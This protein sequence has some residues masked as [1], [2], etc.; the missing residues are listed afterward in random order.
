M[1]GKPK[2][3]VLC[4]GNSARSQM[5][6]AFFRIYA[7]DIFEVHSAGLEPSVVNPFT[8][9][10][11]TEIGYDMSSHRSK[12][13]EEYLGKMVFA[14]VITVCSAA[15][16]LCPTVFPG[17]LNRLHWPF[18]DPAAFVGSDDNKLEVFR[19]V[20]NQIEEK[21]KFWVNEYRET[22]L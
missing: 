1:T 13:V 17:A 10:V 12:G 3:L 6:E 18:D 9:K 21:I 4:T 14:Y 20:R 2:I 11:M 19:K 15:D 5:A 7:D 16:T 22:E 8:I